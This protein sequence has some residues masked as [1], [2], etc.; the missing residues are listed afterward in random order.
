MYLLKLIFYLQRQ[1]RFSLSLNHIST[2][3]NISDPIT[4]EKSMHDADLTRIYMIFLKSDMVRMILTGQHQ[5]ILR[6]PLLFTLG[7]FVLMH[8]VPM[9][10]HKMFDFIPLIKALQM[11]IVSHLFVSSRPSFDLDLPNVPH[12][13][14]LHQKLMIIGGRFFSTE[15]N[16]IFC[17]HLKEPFQQYMLLTLGVTPHDLCNLIYGFFVLYHN[18]IIIIHVSFMFSIYFSLIPRGLQL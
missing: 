3:K 5:T 14:L 2:H 16:H 18:N 6:K 17:W 12:L 4:R 15:A 7:I 1:F 13:P 9:F 11:V 10:F 8:L